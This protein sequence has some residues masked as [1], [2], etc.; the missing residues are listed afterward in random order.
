MGGNSSTYKK[1]IEEKEENSQKE[2][3]RIENESFQKEKEEIEKER[4]GELKY[5]LTITLYSEEECPLKYKNYLNSIKMNDW[6]IKY[7]TN[8]FSAKTNESLITYYKEKSKDKKYFD[9]ILVIIIDSLESFLDLMKNE[10]KNILKEINEN[11]FFDEQPFILFLDK[12]SKDFDIYESE[13]IEIQNKEYK[14]FENDCIKFIRE[15]QEEYNLELNYYIEVK[16]KSKIFN[17]LKIKKDDKENFI[18]INDKKDEFICS[19]QFCEEENENFIHENILNSNFIIIKNLDHNIK[20]NKDY[21]FLSEISKIGTVQIL[22]SYYKPDF[23]KLFN[24]FLRQYE[25]IDKRNLFI[26]NFYQSPYKYFIKFCGYY[27]E[28]GDFL[29]KDKSAKYPSKI[30]I[31]VCGRAGAGKSTLLNVILGEKRC[32]E[33]Q[34]QSVSTYIT[35]YSH[36]KYPIKL[37]DFPGFGD[38]NNAEKLIKHIKGKNSQLKEIK[39]KIHIVIYCFKF[40]ER[41]FLDKEEDVIIELNIKC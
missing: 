8:G 23:N 2:I 22:F 33:G 40:G 41:T 25:L 17:F 15:K 26:E 3:S 13:I 1:D 16:D 32:L 38:K 18:I 27:H 31:A 29:I 24:K 30:N 21:E 7:I 6:N 5:N 35:S 37:I 28:F 11:L 14:D 36:P 19:S 39:E 34:G 20:L 12:N 4:N 10:E 9:D